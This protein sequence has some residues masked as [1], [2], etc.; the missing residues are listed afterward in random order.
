M[1]GLFLGRALAS[2]P[3]NYVTTVPGSAGIII[4]FIAEAVLS[5]VLMLT[6]LFSTNRK[7][8]NSYTGLFAGTLVALFIIFEAPLSGMS[9]NPARSFASA[10]PANIWIAF[11]IYIITA[12]TI[13]MLIAAELYVRLKG[14]HHV[15]C[16]KL[17]HNNEQRCIFNCRY[18]EIPD[19]E[20]K[21]NVTEQEEE[22]NAQ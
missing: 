7:N 3:V 21:E 20:K 8:L 6:V 9:I 13:G 16:A 18:P 5:F 15:Y 14:I 12:P 2:P 22:K 4:A 10:L 17:H 1:I 11:W 19:P